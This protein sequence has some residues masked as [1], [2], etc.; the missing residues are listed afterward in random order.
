MRVPDG[1]PKEL[2]AAL[3]ESADAHLQHDEC[4]VLQRRAADE[5]EKLHKLLSDVDTTMCVH[6][7]VD[8]GTDLHDRIQRA[9]GVE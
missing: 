2:V 6:G 4:R 8:A 5:I 3:R 7:K 1:E 9:Y